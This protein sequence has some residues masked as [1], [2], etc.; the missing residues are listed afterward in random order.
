MSA[1]GEKLLG[2][3]REAPSCAASAR[4]SLSSLPG[5]LRRQGAAAQAWHIAAEVRRQLWLDL[6]AAQSWEQVQ[7]IP[8]ATGCAPLT[9]ERP[10]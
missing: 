10:S 8:S 5:Q 2:S 7:S 6:A 1:A 3:I 4:A 9:F